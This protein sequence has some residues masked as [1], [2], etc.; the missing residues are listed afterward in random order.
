MKK[1]K[2]LREV[3]AAGVTVR[4][5]DVAANMGCT[6][7]VLIECYPDDND[8]CETFVSQ[9]GIETGRKVIGWCNPTNEK[10]MM[11]IIDKVIGR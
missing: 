8:C 3:Y 6:H 5:D 4:A 7:V 11:E 2:T 10:S 9:H 1:I